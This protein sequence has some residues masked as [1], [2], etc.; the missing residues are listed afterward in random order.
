MI[1]TAILLV[2]SSSAITKPPAKPDTAIHFGDYMRFGGIA[3]Y[4]ALDW[5]TTTTGIRLGC[6]E[7]VLPQSVANNSGRL[8]AFEAGATAAQIGA[9]TFLIHRGHRKLAESIDYI[10]IGAGM[11]F[12]SW[13]E[14]SIHTQEART[15]EI[16]AG[17]AK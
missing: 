6:K 13:N 8:A 17:A 1:T 7:V 16:G 4:R 10:S 15:Y 3:A 12:V 5:K 11:L 14:H 2:A 9:S